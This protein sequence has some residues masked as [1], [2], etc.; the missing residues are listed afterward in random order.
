MQFAVETDRAG[1]GQANVRR[2]QDQLVDC[3]Q[4]GSDVIFRFRL[5]QMQ[6]GQF[7]DLQNL[8]ER[9]KKAVLLELTIPED[10]LAT[11]GKRVG[12]GSVASERQIAVEF[13]SNHAMRT[14][15]VAGD[16]VRQQIAK[17]EADLERRTF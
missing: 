14:S 15:G 1:G 4:A 8:T 17:F 6:L 5:F 3:D 9:D 12:I 13:S 10:N 7:F 16:L 11:S 2:A